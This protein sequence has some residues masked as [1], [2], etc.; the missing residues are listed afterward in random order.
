[1]IVTKREYD[2]LGTVFNYAYEDMLKR[3]SKGENTVKLRAAIAVLA[4]MRFK[5]KPKGK[6][7]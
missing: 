1:M 6:R 3:G 7:K 4:K 5:I 2:A